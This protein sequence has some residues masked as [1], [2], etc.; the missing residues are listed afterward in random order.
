MAVSAPSF[1]DARPSDFVSSKPSSAVIVRFPSHARILTYYQE[2]FVFYK[3]GGLFRGP[4][5]VVADVTDP[6][7]RKTTMEPVE[8]GMS[9][10]THLPRHLVGGWSL[11]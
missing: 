6:R 1:L 3:R 2:D 9:E 4:V 5:G 8:T 11:T 10:M 7:L